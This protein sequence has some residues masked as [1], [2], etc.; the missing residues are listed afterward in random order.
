MLPEE[1][2]AYLLFL[3]EENKD[4]KQIISIQRSIQ[5]RL[6]RELTRLRKKVNDDE[7]GC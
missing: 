2:N 3:Q 4:L 6:E 1:L 7:K 5:S